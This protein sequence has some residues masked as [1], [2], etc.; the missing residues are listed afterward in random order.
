MRIFFRLGELAEF[1]TTM[2]RYIKP[3]L[4]N[5]VEKIA[6]WLADFSCESAAN[7]MGLQITI[8]G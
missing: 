3:F 8:I 5:W 7:W 4:V 1:D 2:V 6:D